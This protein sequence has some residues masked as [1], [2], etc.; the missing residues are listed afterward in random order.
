[1]VPPTESL[2]FV[3]GE[4]GKCDRNLE[5]IGGESFWAPTASEFFLK[6]WLNAFL[7][8]HDL[9]HIGKLEANLDS[10]KTALIGRFRCVH[11][12]LYTGTDQELFC[13]RYYNINMPTAYLLYQEKSEQPSEHPSVKRLRWGHWL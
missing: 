3:V 1:M 12:F 2:R 7:H 13:T 9:G 11:I 8:V 5:E 4:L 10:F 6:T